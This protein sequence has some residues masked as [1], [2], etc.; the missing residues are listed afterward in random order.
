MLTLL[1]LSNIILNSKKV[2]SNYDVCTI[3]Y[4]H[5]IDYIPKINIKLYNNYI[6]VYRNLDLY[7]F[8]DKVVRPTKI[9]FK[10]YNKKKG[11]CL[12]IEFPLGLR[13]LKNTKNIYECYE[14]ELREPTY[15][16]SKYIEYYF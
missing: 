12:Q 9:F 15:E 1:E 16:E 5:Y 8:V 10:K 14:S 6:R 4:K 7:F 11:H 3:I 13:V 2:N